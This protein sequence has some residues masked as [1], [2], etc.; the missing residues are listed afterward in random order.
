MSVG[1][2]LSYLL[3]LIGQFS[4]LGTVQA[5]K[6]VPGALGIGIGLS[7]IMLLIAVVKSVTVAH[8]IYHLI[9]A[10]HRVIDNYCEILM[11]LIGLLI[12]HG[13]FSLGVR[14]GESGRNIVFY[15][16][17]RTSLGDKIPFSSTIFPQI[18]I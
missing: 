1:L 10:F 14:D 16:Q 2:P 17:L 4:S 18:P 15:V 12:N 7:L 11:A 8:A 5:Y 9:L 13:T 6:M 3:A